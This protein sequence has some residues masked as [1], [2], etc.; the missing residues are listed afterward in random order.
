MYS[1]TVMEHFNHP[2]NPEVIE[3]ADG[4]V[5]SPTLRK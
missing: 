1:E 5:D 2:H 3:G 4:V